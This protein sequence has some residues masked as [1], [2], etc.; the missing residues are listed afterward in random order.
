LSLRPPVS[1]APQPA[2]PSP[3]RFIGTTHN[4]AAPPRYEHQHEPSNT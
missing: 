1:P 4:E 2:V 3:H